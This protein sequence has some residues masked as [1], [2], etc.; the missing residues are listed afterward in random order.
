M[1]MVFKKKKNSPCGGRSFLRTSL[2]KPLFRKG[3]LVGIATG[4]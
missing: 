3:N 2:Q 4:T 1:K